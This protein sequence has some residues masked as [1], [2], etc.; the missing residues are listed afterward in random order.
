MRDADNK[1]TKS[2]YS[3]YEGIVEAASPIYIEE[4]FAL[5]FTTD[6]VNSEDLKNK[7]WFRVICDASHVEGHVK[8]FHV[9]VPPDIT[10]IQGSVNKTAI[11]GYKS[12]LTYAKSMLICMVFNIITK[13][14]LDDDGNAAG[15]MDVEYINDEQITEIEKALE[16]KNLDP[17]DFLAQARVDTYSLIT[18]NRFQGAMNWIK[19]QKKAE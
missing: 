6:T 16:E 5:S 10:G 13:D 2:K 8:Q 9:D 1:Q 19:R 3:K 14:E 12:A 11:H 17:A 7:G 18:T 15:S 4:G